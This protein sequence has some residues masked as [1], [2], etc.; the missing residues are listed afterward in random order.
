LRFQGFTV[1]VNLPIFAG[2]SSARTR[3]AKI[4]IDREKQNAEYL[5]AQLKSKLTE[6]LEQL[7]TF[8][9]LMDYYKT[10]ATPNADKIITNATKAYQSGDIS[11]VEYVQAIETSMDILFNYTDA[12]Q[13][14]NQTVM[15]IRYLINQ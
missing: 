14:Y 12:I 4:N 11:Y 13:K 3:A 15:N 6:E 1:G 2:S 9:S 5:Q 7:N 8:Q 10:T